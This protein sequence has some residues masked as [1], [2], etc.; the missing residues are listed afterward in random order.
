MFMYQMHLSLWPYNVDND[1]DTAMQVHIE[2]AQALL[3]KS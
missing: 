2:N 1:D 3:F